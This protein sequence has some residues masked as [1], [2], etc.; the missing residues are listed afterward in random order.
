[1]SIEIRELQIKVAIHETG[2]QRAPEVN[3]EVAKRAI[4]AECKKE[5]ARQLKQLNER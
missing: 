1:M 4:L 2:N 5:I 3:L